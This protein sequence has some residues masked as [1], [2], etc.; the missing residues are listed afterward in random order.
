MTIRDRSSGGDASPGT[1]RPA[2]GRRS[3]ADRA[4]ASPA[5]PKSTR[6]SAARPASETPRERHDRIMLEINALMAEIDA[7]LAGCTIPRRSFALVADAE[8]R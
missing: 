2:T 5:K 3:K 4:D 6:A 8:M 7:T 1:P